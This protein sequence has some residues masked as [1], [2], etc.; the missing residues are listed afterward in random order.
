[1]VDIGA[2]SGA[3]SMELARRGARVIAVEADPVWAGRLAG[4]A[5][6][7]GDG[8]LRVVHADFFAWPLPDRPYR[9]VA[10]PPFGSTTAIMRRLLDDP[11]QLLVRA[12]L[13]VQWEVAHKRAAVP[14]A[15]LV[16]TTW[17]P[18]WEFRPGRRIPAASFRPVPRVDG[19]VLTIIRRR[20]P[21]LPVAMASEY[22]EFV[23]RRWPF[24]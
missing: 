13:I 7:E 21:L 9:V 8:R 12:D 16:S 20:P 3:L 10:C 18:W 4:L 14:P 11:E 5:R 6:R 23:R 19:G 15:T 1:V 2:G 22:A 24:A 17:A